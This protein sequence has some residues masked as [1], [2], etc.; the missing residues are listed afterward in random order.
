MSL[1][2]EIASGIGSLV[3]AGASYLGSS[4]QAKAA[5]QAGDRSYAMY[6]QQRKDLLPQIQLGQQATN[7]LRDIYLTGE[8]PFTAAPGYDFRVAEGLKALERGAAARGRQFSGAQG[9]ALTQYGQNIASDE[10]NQGFNRLASLAGFGQTATGQAHSA[11]NTYVNAAN[12]AGQNAAAARA[13]GY[14]GIGSSINQ[15]INNALFL[16]YLGG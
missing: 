15:G 7:K 4:A 8:V 1:F 2:G 11:G 12:T 16:R 5:Q 9:K 6:Q 3:G 13:S 10:Y 14:E